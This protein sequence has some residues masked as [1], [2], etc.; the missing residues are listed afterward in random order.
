[1]N[2]F[3]DRAR[4]WDKDPL[5]WDRSEAI[6]NSLLEMIPVTPDMEALEYGAGTGILSFLLS[7]KFSEIT[8]MD[9]SEEMVKVMREKVTASQSK[10]LKP[11]FWDLVQNDSDSGKFDCIFSQMV[12]HHIPDIE[13]IIC[14]WRKMLKTGGYLA[15]ADLF[16]EDGTFHNADANVHLGFDPEELSDTLRLAGFKDIKHKTCF[17][18]R[19]NNGRNYPV[20]L[21]IAKI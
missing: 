21:L 11:L 3:N 6:A 17:V 7:E 10:N 18:I 5:H 2:A 19:R 8:L 13:N 14:K 9:N 1:M 12:L 4:N 15:I 16:S 20:F